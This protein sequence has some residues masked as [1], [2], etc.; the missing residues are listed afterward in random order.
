MSHRTVTAQPE[1]QAFLNRFAVAS[2]AA[3]TRT[4]ADLAVGSRQYGGEALAPSS[5]AARVAAGQRLAVDAVRAALPGY[6]ATRVAEFMGYGGSGAA[7][8]PAR[9]ARTPATTNATPQQAKRLRGEVKAHVESS[10]S[11][12]RA[13]NPA[14]YSRYPRGIRVRSGRSRHNYKTHKRRRKFPRKRRNAQAKRRYY[15][16][17]RG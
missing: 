9:P 15:G 10:I 3:T 13:N 1:W 11:E 16:R 8:S 4:G 2:G 6:A 17:R 7:G 12:S 5:R 14:R